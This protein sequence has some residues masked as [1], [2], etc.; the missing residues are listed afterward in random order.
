MNG[1]VNCTCPK[2]LTPFLHIY[3]ATPISELAYCNCTAAISSIESDL[4]KMVHLQISWMEVNI[5]PKNNHSFRFLL[6]FKDVVIAITSEMLKKMA[7]VS[8]V[9]YESRSKAKYN[10]ER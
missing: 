9:I 3:R 7:D 2:Q 5:C 10:I 6:P 1:I 8:V 4:K